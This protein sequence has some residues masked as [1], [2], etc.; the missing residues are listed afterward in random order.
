VIS[1]YFA[2]SFLKTGDVPEMSNAIPTALIPGGKAEG[3]DARGHK[4]IK[5]D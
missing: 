5:G 2:Y 1:S 3:V 4:R